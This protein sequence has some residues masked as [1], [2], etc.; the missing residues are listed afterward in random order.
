MVGWGGIVG[1]VLSLSLRFSTDL[2]LFL[3][4]AILV[5]GCIGFARL[6]LNAHN[7]LQVY[8]GFLVGFLTVL[9][10]YIL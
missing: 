6:R 7:P 9:T 4:L 3:I 5:S 1:L 2:M 10:V 8:A